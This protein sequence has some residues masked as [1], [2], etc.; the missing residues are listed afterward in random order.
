MPTFVQLQSIQCHACEHPFCGSV[1]RQ[2]KQQERASFPPSTSSS[3]TSFKSS[4]AARGAP[5]RGRD[6]GGVPHQPPKKKA[7]HLRYSEPSLH[8]QQQHPH[9]GAGG[10]PHGTGRASKGTAS[11]RSKSSS[12]NVLRDGGKAGRR[13]KEGTRRRSSSGSIGMGRREDDESMVL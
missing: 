5:A 10:H 1:S 3:S 13:E 4:S 12:S 8:H 9:Y 7:V 2:E 11:G 6:A